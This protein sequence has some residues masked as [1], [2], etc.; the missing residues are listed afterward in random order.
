MAIPKTEQELNH[1]CVTGVSH[2]KANGARL[3]ISANNIT[4]ATDAEGL[5]VTAYEAAMNPT[6]R[7]VTTIAEKNRLTLLEV[8][9]L[10][11]IFGDIPNSKLTQA[12]RDVLDIP[13]RLYLHLVLPLPTSKPVGKLI[14]GERLKHTI[15]IVDSDSGKKAQ[16][17]GTSACEIW[18]KKG[19]IPPK[20]EKEL[21]YA[22]STSNHTFTCEFDGEDAGLVVYYWIRWVN[23]K[24]E[25]GTWGQM[26]SGNIQ[27]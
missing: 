3:G 18:Y 10:R 2:I 17:P 11:R 4:D 27:G 23:S 8:V 1:Y 7:T 15:H 14:P 25:K 26:F 13:E 22:G 5:R 6:T 9:I 12:D 16:P 20:S 24:N 19:G 21:S